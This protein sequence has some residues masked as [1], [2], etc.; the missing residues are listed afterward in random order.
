M[1][2]Q[3]LYG[4]GG[5]SSRDCAAVARR[6]YYECQERD[7]EGVL[8]SS[9]KTLTALIASRSRGS[10]AF[11]T[12]KRDLNINFVP[13][14]FSILLQ[15]AMSADASGSIVCCWGSPICGVTLNDTTPAGIARHLRNY[16]FP[17][18]Q[19]HNRLRGTCQ[20]RYAGTVPCDREMFQG[21]F[22][23]HI[24]T[25]F[26]TLS[27]DIVPISDDSF[28]IDKC[29]WPGA[30]AWFL[31]KDGPITILH[32]RLSIWQIVTVYDR[33][34]RVVFF[35]FVVCGAYSPR[36]DTDEVLL[37]DP[38]YLGVSPAIDTKV[39]RTA[40][41]SV[42]DEFPVH[43]KNVNASRM[44]GGKH[45]QCYDRVGLGFLT[46][47][48]R[49]LNLKRR[50][51]FLVEASVCTLRSLTSISWSGDVL[52]AVAVLRMETSRVTSLVVIV[53]GKMPDGCP[54]LDAV[55]RGYE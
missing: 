23:K 41:P 37:K 33:D 32:I 51:K 17:V 10:I 55:T 3:A 44:S 30:F 26:D 34:C 19:W 45:V 21:N 6:A 35:N 16:H 9:S 18:G 47:P 31:C 13:P 42:P 24:A 1:T 15:I 40:S 22:G 7:R 2:S 39:R 49:H 43:F 36:L 11:V 48:D 20:W 54:L 14:K 53:V 4:S 25:C 5:C 8:L 27:L 46:D 52:A 12:F 29:Q 38:R 50:R 28:T